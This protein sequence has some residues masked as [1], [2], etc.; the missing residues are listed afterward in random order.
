[1]KAYL[2]KAWYYYKRN[3][4]A[5]T[6]FTTLERVLGINNISYEWTECSGKELKRQREQVFPEPIRISILVP[7]Y[8]TDPVFLRQ[9]IDSVKNQTY[10][11]WELVIADAGKTDTVENIVK[12]Y[13]QKHTDDRNAIVY[14]RLTNNAGISANTNEALK[15]ASGEYIGLLDHDDVLTPD[16]LFE[17]ASCI[18]KAKHEGS[19][20]KMLYSDED[21]CD[22]EMKHFYEPHFKEDFNLDLILSNNYICHF[23]VM[24]AE[25]MKQIQ[26]QPDFDGAQDYKLVLDAVDILQK[27]Q[28]A[29]VHI[30]KVLYHWRC[31]TG[32]TAQN[33]QSKLYAYEAGKRA[34]AS[35]CEK[36]GWS[37]VKVEHL[38]HLG[39]YKIVYG[40]CAAGTTRKVNVKDEME[41][42]LTIRKD[43]GA[44]GGSVLRRGTIVGGRYLEN[45]NVCYYKL[46]H[47]FGGYMHRAVLMQDAYGLDL[48]C[49]VV[50]EE[51]QPLLK[52]IREKYGIDKAKRHVSE[53]SLRKANEEFAQLLRDKKYLMLWNPA[54]KCKV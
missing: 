36:Q 13:M 44:V 45:G 28:S 1:M 14:K 38:P 18:E 35:F 53:E 7:A 20:V 8:E 41:K 10:S 9:M 49:I 25:L 27:E 33:P 42:L 43:V 26:F 23:L 29:I 24:K 3:G 46:Y 37:N 48:R 39:F 22:M 40:N 16:A 52:E 15:L 19:I 12:E 32:S 6:F 47:R 4:I 21:K 51:L 11:Y 2:Q 5:N 50:K 54:M 31:H 34:V 30:P 17:M